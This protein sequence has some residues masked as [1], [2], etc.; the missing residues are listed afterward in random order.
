MRFCEFILF[1]Y[2]KMVYV[3]DD[4]HRHGR[5]VDHHSGGAAHPE[6]GHILFFLTHDNHEV[7]IHVLSVVDN[8]FRT[9][10]FHSDGVHRWKCILITTSS[11]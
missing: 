5:G 8:G 2:C 1:A 9:V 4:E 3:G 7:H 6:V 11:M 10:G